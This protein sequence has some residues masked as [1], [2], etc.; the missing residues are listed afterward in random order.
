MRRADNNPLQPRTI[1]KSR[2]FIMRRIHRLTLRTDIT[3]TTIITTA[4]IAAIPITTTTITIM[5]LWAFRA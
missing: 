5:S 4:P 1:Y 2:K 3:I